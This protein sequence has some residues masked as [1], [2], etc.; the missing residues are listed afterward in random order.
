M[1]RLTEAFLEKGWI[2]NTDRFEAEEGFYDFD[3]AYYPFKYE[4]RICIGNDQIVQGFKNL[5]MTTKIGMI[6][7]LKN[8]Q[9]HK[10]LD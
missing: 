7:V 3:F 10:K 8:A 1:P 6:N 5:Y 4:Q 9:R 2:N